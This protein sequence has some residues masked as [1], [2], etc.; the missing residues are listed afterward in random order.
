MPSSVAAKIMS[1]LNQ[2]NLGGNPDFESSFVG[3]SSGVV[4]RNI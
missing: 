3:T 4:L 1:C 2:A